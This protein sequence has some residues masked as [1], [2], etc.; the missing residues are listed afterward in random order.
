MKLN[1]LLIGSTLVAALG[2]F[3][4]GFDTAVISGTTEA[5]KQV[6][7]LNTVFGILAAYLTNYVIAAMFSAKGASRRVSRLALDVWSRGRPG[8][9]VFPSCVADPGEPTL[10]G[11]TASARG[12]AGD[13]TE[14]REW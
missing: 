13:L 10:A 12:S 11:E 7:Q 14:I 2:G 9:A 1:R 8:S 3:L 6:F 4:F 5:F